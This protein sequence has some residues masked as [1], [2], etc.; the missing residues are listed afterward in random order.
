MDAVRA[1]CLQELKREEEEEEEH[2]IDLVV[3]EREKSN[4]N[5]EEEEEEE[6]GHRVGY[7]LDSSSIYHMEPH[8]VNVVEYVHT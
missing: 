1:A 8:E 2:R 7:D 3:E 5:L 6:E 4:G